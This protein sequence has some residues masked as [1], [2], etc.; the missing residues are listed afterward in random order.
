LKGGERIFKAYQSSPMD[1][2]K[3]VDKENLLFHIKSETNPT[4]WY[5]VSLKTHYC[6]CPDRV[7]TCKHIFGVQSIVKEFFEKPKDDEFVEEILHMESNM[8]TIDFMS[9]SQVDEPIEDA[10][11]NDAMREK[12]LNSLSELDS[13]CKASL[14]VDNEEE[15]KRK[16][17]AL[18][19]CIATFLEPSSFE[20]PKT[21][22]LPLRGSIASIQENV[23][24][25]RM[26]H[27]RKRTTS[28]IGEGSTP[29]PP[30]KRP[31]HML[32]SHS[33]QKRS[34]FRKLPKVTC[35]IC[36]TKT[37]VEGGANSICCKNCD[38]EMFVK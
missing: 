16:L 23:K 24:R 25:T 6:D 13:L 11:S 2:L 4:L 14:D 35:D 26:G 9:P 7:S 34:I 15:M 21:I 31:P 27:G 22:D 37:L 12:M 3:V 17:Q 19:A 29:R 5:S 20:R 33:K 36:A 38:H 8:E 10:T 30:L 32:V 1:V 28:E 18:Q